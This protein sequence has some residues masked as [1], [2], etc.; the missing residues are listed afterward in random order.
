MAADKTSVL[1]KHKESKAEYLGFRSQ[2]KALGAAG[3]EIVEPTAESAA[4]DAGTPPDTPTESEPATAAR[5]R[6]A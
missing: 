3:W 1:F 6:K 4:D 2:A 5:T